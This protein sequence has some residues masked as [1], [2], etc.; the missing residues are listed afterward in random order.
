MCQDKITRYYQDFALSILLIHHF[1]QRHR[2]ITANAHHPKWGACGLHDFLRS[3]HVPISGREPSVKQH[4]P[5]T[6]KHS[7]Y[8]QSKSNDIS[9]DKFLA[10]PTWGPDWDCACCWYKQPAFAV[11]ARWG[12]RR[13]RTKHEVPPRNVCDFVDLEVP[14][15]KTSIAC[16]KWRFVVET[17]MRRG[18]LKHINL[19]VNWCELEELQLSSLLSHITHNHVNHVT[20][21]QTPYAVRCTMC[22]ISTKAILTTTAFAWLFLPAVDVAAKIAETLLVASH[23]WRCHESKGYL[24]CNSLRNSQ[25]QLRG[26]KKHQSKKTRSDPIVRCFWNEYQYIYMYIYIYII[27]SIHV[28]KSYHI[29]DNLCV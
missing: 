26:K 7:Q 4:V 9:F 18:C 12:S 13:W 19:Y 20:A 25:I 1:D 24:Q 27:Y 10:G 23:L 22:V 17:Y 15:I 2:C 11:E 14:Q 28:C 29:Y 16:W 5:K 3:R 6:S 21:C 8:R